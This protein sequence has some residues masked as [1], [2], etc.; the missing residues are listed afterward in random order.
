MLANRRVRAVRH[1]AP[2]VGGR[3]IDGPPSDLEE[4]TYARDLLEADP[5][6]VDEVSRSSATGRRPQGCLIRGHVGHSIPC[7]GGVKIPCVTR[8]RFRRQT[9]YFEL[10]A[11]GHAASRGVPG[12]AVI[13][14]RDLYAAASIAITSFVRRRERRVANAVRTRSAPLGVTV[15]TLPLTTP[16]VIAGSRTRTRSSHREEQQCRK[17]ARQNMRVAR[18]HIEFIRA[19]DVPEL[20]ASE[21]F[22]GALERRL[23]IDDET[24]A[25][26]SLLTF[27][28]GWSGDLS[29]GSRSTE[30]FVLRG[31]IELAGTRL[32]PARTS[33]SRAAFRPRSSTP[34]PRRLRS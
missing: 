19:Q 18:P 8:D 15:R 31:E 10:K 16:I 12:W 2:A 33:T 13:L 21:P 3:S 25:Y 28:D 5:R 30:V 34:S 22:R 29:D 14:A 17:S 26:T 7:R 27:P 24:G 32:A 23:S 6:G 9:R 11:A 1:R 20:E 4:A